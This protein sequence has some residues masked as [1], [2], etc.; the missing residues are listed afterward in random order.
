MKASICFHQVASQSK[1]LVL[2]SFFFFFFN[3]FCHTHGIW[4][5]LGQG[6]NLSPSC[7]LCHSCSNTGSFNTL[8]QDR[9]QT[10][11]SSVTPA[12]VVGFLIHC[13][14]AETPM[15]K[16]LII[17]TIHLTRIH[18]APNTRWA[19]WWVLSNALRWERHTTYL[20]QTSMSQTQYVLNS[21]RDLMSAPALPGLTLRDPSHLLPPLSPSA[22]LSPFAEPV[23]FWG[24][25]IV[26]C[27]LL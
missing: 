21:W 20:Q 7:D 16:F 12:T 14:T 10:H 11:T 2:Y 17:H 13:A 23:F 3:F 25:A 4:K 15:I 26:P 8:C 18:R 9:Y 19:L 1:Y 27:S 5:F 22:S 24:A 6:L